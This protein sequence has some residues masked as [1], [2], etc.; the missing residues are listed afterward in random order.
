MIKIKMTLPTVPFGNV[1]LEMDEAD[2]IRAKEIADK[3]L[4]LYA[5]IDSGP[6]GPQEEAVKAIVNGLGAT[7]L[8][9][10]EHPAVPGPEAQVTPAWERPADPT[11]GPEAPAVN[12]SVN[13]E[14]F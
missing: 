7:V 8:E 12:T 11:S 10:I 9:T 4:T 2:L 1:K 14:G 6:E 13:W 5:L 3:A